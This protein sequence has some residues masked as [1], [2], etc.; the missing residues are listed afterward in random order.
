MELRI[1]SRY[2]PPS[3]ERAANRSRTFWARWKSWANHSPK[4]SNRSLP[5]F[6]AETT[7]QNSGSRK[8]ARNAS[9]NSWAAT[10]RPRTRSRSAS[11]GGAPEHLGRRRRAQR[12]LAGPVE[13][14]LAGHIGLAEQ[15]AAVQRGH[16]N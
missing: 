10:E 2:E 6:V 4:E 12:D 3:T 5:D 9:M 8:Y 7:S 14:R 13:Q 16:R 15:E 11:G 1:H